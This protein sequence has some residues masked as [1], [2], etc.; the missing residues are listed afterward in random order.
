MSS[1]NGWK[2]RGTGQHTCKSGQVVTVARVPKE[3]LLTCG[4][5]P[6]PLMEVVIK[7]YKALDE[8]VGNGQPTPE[9]LL[10]M[11]EIVDAT[12]IAA[13]RYNNP[14]AVMGEPTNE[15]EINVRDIPA[16]DRVDIFMEAQKS[17][18]QIPVETKGGETSLEALSQFPA[19]AGIT[20]A[21]LDSAGSESNAQS[22]SGAAG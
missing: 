8:Q 7:A 21:L 9:Q 22:I 5:V 15:D 4:H 18:P 13:L 1:T 17:F 2:Q 12:L 14:R 16:E 6:S 19:E 11:P 20:D 10:A 3:T